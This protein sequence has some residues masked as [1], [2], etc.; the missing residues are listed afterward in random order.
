[1]H[2]DFVAG[3]LGA[4][5]RDLTAPLSLEICDLRDASDQVSVEDTSDSYDLGDIFCILHHE[6]K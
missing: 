4:W 3:Q 1:M 2:S 6:Q 5:E